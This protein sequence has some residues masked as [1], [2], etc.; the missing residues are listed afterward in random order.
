MDNNIEGKWD[1]NLDVKNQD[2][3]K[4]IKLKNKIEYKNN[5]LEAEEIVMRNL[6][7]TLIFKGK[8]GEVNGKQDKNN[9]LFFYSDYM[10]RDNNNK[11]FR[12]ENLGKRIDEDNNFHMTM[13]INGD[14]LN[15]KYI[16]LI[17]KNIPDFIT[18]GTG[19]YEFQYLKLQEAKRVNMRE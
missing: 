14:L 3:G 17:P 8:V 11:Y 2:E 12:I 7:N 6:T 16:E 5:T 10:I 18:E 4:R 19:G 15:S 1:F 13:K 9:A